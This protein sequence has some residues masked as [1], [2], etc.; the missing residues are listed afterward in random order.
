MYITGRRRTTYAWS[1]KCCTTCTNTAHTNIQTYRKFHR[2]HRARNKVII[3]LGPS[4]SSRLSQ[5]FTDFLAQLF[6][7]SRFTDETRTGEYQANIEK[8]NFLLISQLRRLR[9]GINYRNFINAIRLDYLPSM[10]VAAASLRLNR[11]STRASSY[12]TNSF[13]LLRSQCTSHNKN[14]SRCLAQ[15]IAFFSLRK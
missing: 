13:F 6:P 12:H 7:L 14:S 10:N 15:F 8:I 4:V 5:E 9:T 11:H 1:D 3:G 2:A